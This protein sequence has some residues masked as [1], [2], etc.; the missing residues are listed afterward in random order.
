MTAS[1]DPHELTLAF[2]G[3]QAPCLFQLTEP[4]CTKP[5]GWVAYFRHI[6]PSDCG[7]ALKAPV[8]SEHKRML[9][10]SADPFWAMWFHRDPATCDGGC[11]KPVELDRF[12]RIGGGL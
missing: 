3:Y 11:G 9:A 12:D 4:E 2:H 6:L 7:E 5:A 10:L 1:T 8:C